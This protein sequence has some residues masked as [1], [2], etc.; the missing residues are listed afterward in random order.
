MIFD[1][2]GLHYNISDQDIIQIGDERSICST[3]VNYKLHQ[4]KLPTQTVLRI[5]VEQLME[6]TTSNANFIV[7]VEDRQ[8]R[9]RAIQYIIEKSWNQI[10][11]VMENCSI[12]PDVA[13]GQGVV[14]FPLN[15]ILSKTIV[16]NNVLMYPGCAIGHLV[17]INNNTIIQSSCFVGG[18]ANIGEQCTLGLRSTVSTHITIPPNTVLGS[19]SS[20][21]KSPESSGYFLG[22]PARKVSNESNQ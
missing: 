17:T 6:I 20:L 5:S 7:T 8:L 13:I 21:T 3:D 15:V 9:N 10:S 18:T 22:T 1:R 19:F 14:I 4:Y 11:I 12:M 16:S 2:T